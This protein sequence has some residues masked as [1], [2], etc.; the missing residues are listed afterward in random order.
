MQTLI[1]MTDHLA[2]LT[3][4]ELRIR[5]EIVEAQLAEAFKLYEQGRRAPDEAVE[6]MQTYQDAL[7]QAIDRIAFVNH[8]DQPAKELAV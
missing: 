6:R 5:Q 1:S 3:I 7:M 8:H 4:P 2:T